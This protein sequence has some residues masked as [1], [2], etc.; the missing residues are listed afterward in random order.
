MFEWFCIVFQLSLNELQ[1]FIVNCNHHLCWY[2][3]DAKKPNA[4]HS[5][6]VHIGFHIVIDF[7]FRFFSWYLRSIQLRY[8][9][10]KCHLC[11]K[12]SYI[13]NQT[14]KNVMITTKKTEYEI[15][16]ISFAV[17]N[18]TPPHP[19][20]PPSFEWKTSQ[21]SIESNLSYTFV[22]KLETTTIIWIPAEKCV[23]VLGN[24]HAIPDSWYAVGMPNRNV[25]LSLR[26]A[27]YEISPYEMRW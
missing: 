1:F 4:R 19:T 10:L 8:S 27:F 15:V 13:M 9:C 18:A 11:S 23:R 7:S 25:N 21:F 6:I 12:I 16:D 26:A 2:N 14:N 17:R 3:F 20:H 24:H 5:L 22:L